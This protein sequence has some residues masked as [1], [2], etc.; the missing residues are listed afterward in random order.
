MDVQEDRLEVE[1]IGW[2]VD[3]ESWSLKYQVIHGDPGTKEV[4]ND[5]DDLLETRILHARGMEMPVMCACVDSG[6]HF[7]DE[8]YSFCK[9][10][11]R[12]G[13]R[14]YV[15]RGGSVPWKPV[16]GKP[17]KNNSHH[18]KMFL[19]GTETAKDSI[20]SWLKVE[21]A[22]QP[23]YCHFPAHYTDDYF[24]GLT[25]EKKVPQYKKGRAIKVYV[26]KKKGIRNE[27]LDLRVYNLA[28]L[29]ILNPN[30]KALALRME[31]ITPK[32]TTPAPEKS[33]DNG[34]VNPPPAPKPKGKKRRR[35]GFVNAYK[36]R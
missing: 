16:I 33:P 26:P 12:Q 24:N 15:V 28:A 13:R 17:S 1:I 9:K 34:T 11:Q 4:W 31:R 14:I 18:A 36:D 10:K 25:S 8:V 30:F 35:S 21:E 19:V 22:G 2:G 27:P 32:S 29:K 5:L 20:F 23:G 7:A 6:G 3:N